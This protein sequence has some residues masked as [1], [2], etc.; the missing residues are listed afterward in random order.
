M[1]CSV[2]PGSIDSAAFIVGR[3]VEREMWESVRR[4][5]V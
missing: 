5:G 3:I 1:N 4:E 2:F